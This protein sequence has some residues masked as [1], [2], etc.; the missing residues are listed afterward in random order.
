M[1]ERELVCWRAF[2]LALDAWMAAGCPDGELSQAVDDT[3][4]AYHAV[5]AAR[6]VVETVAL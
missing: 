1:N 2:E 5:P 3:W 6:V 4:L